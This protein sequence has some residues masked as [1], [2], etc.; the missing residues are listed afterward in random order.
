MINE[1]NICLSSLQAIL[2]C[3]RKLPKYLLS[4]LIKSRNITLNPFPFDKVSQLEEYADSSVCPIYLLIIQSLPF[5][6]N[7]SDGKVETFGK[8]VSK[9]DHISGHLSKCIAI[10]SVLRGLRHN[11][12]KNRCYIPL[13]ILVKNRMSQQE[14]LRCQPSEKLENVFFDLACIAKSHLD[15]TKTLLKDSQ[16]HPFVDLFLPAIFCDIYLTRLEKANFNALSENVARKP[17]FLPLQFYFRS[18]RLLHLHY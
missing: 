14:L 16:V 17:T 8:V 1:L 9:L 11:G 7:A 6:I 3:E 12:R 2:K 15:T 10:T 5:M 4:K 13:E 18:I